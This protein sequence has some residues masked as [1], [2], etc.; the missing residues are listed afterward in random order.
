MALKK[1]LVRGDV[2]YPRALGAVRRYVHHAIDHKE[3]ITVRQN[4]A[5]VVYKQ[6]VSQ[7]NLAFVEA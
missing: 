6:P 5:Y 1:L 7:I 4:P 3:R 2:L